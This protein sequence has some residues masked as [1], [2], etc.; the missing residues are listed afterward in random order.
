VTAPHLSALDA[1]ILSRVAA[2]ERPLIGRP[3][4]AVVA[5]AAAGLVEITHT[6][7]D[8]RGWVAA[9]DAGR[10]A[11]AALGQAAELALT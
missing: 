11:I 10:A 6:T 2:D 3:D 4:P 9:T 1:L 7:H 8:R 5:L